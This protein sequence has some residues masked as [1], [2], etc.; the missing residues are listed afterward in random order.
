MSQTPTYDFNRANSK[1]ALGVAT[2]RELF[3]R[4]NV[5]SSP[6]GQAPEDAAHR[7]PFNTTDETIVV[8]V[9]NLSAIRPRRIIVDYIS[10]F[11][12]GERWAQEQLEQGR[13]VNL[14]MLYSQ[15]AKFGDSPATRNVQPTVVKIEPIDGFLTWDGMPYLVP[16]HDEHG[17]PAPWCKIPEGV[18]DL[19]YGNWKRLHEMSP[20]E[21]SNELESVRARRRDFVVRRPVNEDFMKEN[22]EV[23]AD[24]DNDYAFLVFDR[25][26]VKPTSVAID[27][28]RVYAGRALEV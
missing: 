7:R 2:G 26:V 3:D 4:Y 24:K 27:M 1:G 11:R 9:R 14:D 20:K 8:N 12:G 6:Y 21:R 13:Q 19:Y 16:S 25:Q 22:K 17:K 18:M 15:M 5:N 28:E 10:M 23:A